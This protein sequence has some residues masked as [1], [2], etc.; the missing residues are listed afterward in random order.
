MRCAYLALILVFST[1]LDAAIAVE[2]D[3]KPDWLGLVGTV[4]PFAFPVPGKFGAVLTARFVTPWQ[5]EGAY[6][7]GTT[8][9]GYSRLKVLSLREENF[10]LR[11]RRYFGRWLHTFLGLGERRMTLETLPQISRF[12]ESQRAVVRTP[13]VEG[14]FGSEWRPYRGLILGLEW[15]ALAI[16]IGGASVREQGDLIA[17]EPVVD[18][19]F[20]LAGAVPGGR[21]L[22]LQIGWV[23]YERQRKILEAPPLVPPPESEPL[24]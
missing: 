17:N 24:P 4:E 12:H 11:G 22:T 16:P 21:V 9:F 6:A 3:R 14:G 10:T 15:F 2:E 20:H 1:R 18:K 8:G 7:T 13:F 23:F 5:V 19:A